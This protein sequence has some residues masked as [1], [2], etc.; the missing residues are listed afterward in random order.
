MSHTAHLD[1][2]Q[3]LRALSDPSRV[4]IL[5]ALMAAPMTITQLGARFGHHA[6]WVR[7]H[8]LQLERVGLVELAEV[9]TTRNYTERFYRATSQTFAVNT[10]ILPAP[11]DDGLLVV[12]GSDD[13]AL[14]M[15]ADAVRADPGAPDVLTLP[16]GSLEGLIALRQGLGHAAG[17]HLLDAETGE[18]NGPFA[19][20]LFP[21]RALVLVTLAHREQG[22]L[23][24]PG[25]PLGVRS[26]ADGAACGARIVNRNIGSGTRIMLDRLL[27][28]DGLAPDSLPGYETEV[29]THAE[30][31]QAITTGAAD[32][33][34]GIQAA[35]DRYG[36][37]FVPLLE[38]RY[39]LIIAREQYDSELV[40]PLL[41]HLHSAAFK[42]AVGKLAGYSSRRSGAEQE[43]AA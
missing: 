16:M 1:Q 21:G 12:V 18:F 19:R 35:A 29:F 36:L 41:R 33:G 32:I 11:G 42:R 4:A 15:L 8:V 10:V 37:A 14:T 7:H 31:A 28:A 22:L 30:T 6:A 23:L 9:R 34:L 27:A 5:R 40:A 38:E 13:M 20:R 25:N 39:D 26:L 17:C 2:P 24:A 43:L 3:H